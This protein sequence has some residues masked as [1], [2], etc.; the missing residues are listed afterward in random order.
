MNKFLFVSKSGNAA[1]IAL[2]LQKEG[3]EVIL[4]IVDQNYH[5]AF[6]FMVKKTKDWKSKLDWIKNDGVIV[7][8]D[9][10]FGREADELR[11]KGFNVFGGSKATD[12]LES[13]REFG[14][15]VFSELG[16]ETVILKDF[17]NIEDAIIFAQEHKDR[18]VIKKNDES[19]QTLSYVGECDDS[20]DVI[21]LLR[22]YLCNPHINKKKISLQKKVDGVEICLARVFNGTDWVGPIKYSIEHKRFFNDDLGPMTSEMGTL[23]WFSDDEN[24]E[25]YKK[26]LAKLKPFLIKHNFRGEI[27]VSS[28]VNDKNVI[29]LECTPRFGTPYVHAE[30][31]LQNFKW[32]K[33]IC[34]VSTG[35]NPVMKWQK[36]YAVVTLLATPPFPYSHSMRCFQNIGTQTFFD[37][38][39]E[40]DFKHVHYEGISKRPD[41]DSYYLADNTGYALY[42]T[43]V[44]KTIAEAREKS[45]TILKKI[46]VP[47]SFYRTDIGVKFERKDLKQLKKWGYLQ[48]H[49]Y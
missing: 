8:D 27:D 18:W 14:Q 30:S 20:R 38:L 12:K 13:D 29:I 1:N 35:K 43:G 41:I 25:I 47:K 10:C 31:E 34:D 24:C 33:L 37:G 46:I 9:S 5:G 11:I 15:K 7:F 39:T 28:M 16:M 6:D 22:N 17:D 32:S 44:G 49:F 19:S 48:S 3:S 21:S 4:H 42:S 45:L 2:L 40:N 36:G 26:S 23:G